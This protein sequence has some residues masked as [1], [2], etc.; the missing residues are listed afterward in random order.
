MGTLANASAILPEREGGAKRRVE[1]GLK[2]L[3]RMQQRLGQAA[4]PKL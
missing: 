2:L 4:A 3:A 1:G